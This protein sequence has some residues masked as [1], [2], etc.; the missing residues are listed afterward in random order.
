MNLPKQIF[1]SYDIRGIYPNELNE[2]VAEKIAE[3]YLSIVSQRINKPAS[4]MKIIIAR[5]ARNSSENLCLAFKNFLVSKGVIV[6]DIGL[7][8]VDA[9]Y[10]MVGKKNYDGGVMVTA[11]H[12]PGDYGGFKMVSQGVNWIRGG[13]LLNHVVEM[14]TFP[15]S[16]QGKMEK[17]DVWND[18]LNHIF[19]FIDVDK[20]KSKKIV[21][22]SGNGMAGV[23]ISKI[24]ERLPQIKLVPLFFEVDGNFPSRDPN[25]L[26]PGA[27]DQIVKKVITEK[28]DAGFIF[29][30]DAD[31]VFLVD[32]QGRFL[33]GDETLLVIAKQVL[34]KSPGAGIVYN[35]ISSKNVKEYV[36]KKGGRAIRSEVGYVNMG[37]H[38][39][40]ENGLMGGEVSAH[41]SFKDNYFADSGFIAFLMILQA[42]SIEG[43]KISD[44]MEKN[45]IWHKAEDVNL[46]IENKE[47]ALNKIREHYQKN[48]LD[49]IDGVT[50]EFENWWFNVRPSNTEPLLRVTIECKNEEDIERRKKEVMDII[51]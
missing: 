22:D 2:E 30:A 40:E 31:R 37:T 34:E 45:Q 16:D 35:L 20:I 1:K 24:I 26:N 8:A 18:Y 14:K 13:E 17:I 49:E 50:V 41:F 28:A 33:K 42:I 23:M 43:F 10:M 3:L 21:V 15:D 7:I 12:N 11:S 25:P 6:H 5:D 48:I 19:S 44:F 32:D 29:D 4:K 36:Q 38:M 51:K 46:E 9:V 27:S 39:K 47:E